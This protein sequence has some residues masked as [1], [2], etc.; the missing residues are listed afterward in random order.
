[1]A[2]RPK[3]YGT[4]RSYAKPAGELVNGTTADEPELELRRHDRKS[5]SARSDKD[6]NL[7]TVRIEGKQ[8][9]LS[10]GLG[11][12]DG[13]ASSTPAAE[14]DAP[15]NTPNG[16]NK[17]STVSSASGPLPNKRMS[18]QAML[19]LVA[20]V[21][22]RGSSC[23]STRRSL[24]G[25]A[26]SKDQNSITKTDLHSIPIA[27]TSPSQ[28]KANF[29]SN[30]HTKQQQSPIG[31]N[32]DLKGAPSDPR[33]L[34]IWVAQLISKCSDNRPLQAMSEPKQKDLSSQSERDIEIG[35]TLDNVEGVRMTRGK[36]RKRLQ[37]LKG[38]EPVSGTSLCPF[39][40]YISI[41]KS[42]WPIAPNIEWA[43]R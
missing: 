25:S 24:N 30:G 27:H 32:I 8:D 29:R 21:K 5:A 19:P 22:E 15:S 42:G 10:K 6:G 16:D 35:D 40:V 14:G 13:S 18:G 33:S 23:K 41:P 12:E 4:R 37:Q 34:A 9:I 38:K 2:P 3:T 28:A 17:F 20:S 11:K 7:G 36:E 43:K 1:M 31:C 26:T 39:F